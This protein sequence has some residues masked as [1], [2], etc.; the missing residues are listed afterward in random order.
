MGGAIP[1]PPAGFKL[2][3]PPPPDG[4][5]IDSPGDPGVPNIP[6][7]ASQVADSATKTIGKIIPRIGTQVGG[8]EAGALLGAPLGPL[9]SV[10]GAA[11]GGG[12]GNVVGSKLPEAIGGDPSESTLHAFGWGAIPEGAGR[13]IAG[14][15]ESR[16]AKR[17]A[18]EAYDA[19][20]DALDKGANP[21]PA[22]QAGRTAEALGRTTL[23]S[24]KPLTGEALSDATNSLRDDIRGPITAMRRQLGEPI[25]DAYKALKEDPTPLDPKQIADIQE[26]SQNVREDMIS[27]YPKAKAILQR[28]KNLSPPEAP[29]WM[30]PAYKGDHPPRP[31]TPE[32]FAAVQ[33]YL[34]GVK[35]YKPPTW[36]DIR[37]LRQANNQ[38]LR[39]AQGGD[40]HASAG[41]QQALDEQLMTK[42]PAGISRDRELY[43]SFMNRFPWRDATRLDRMGTPGEL[44]DYAFGGTPERAAEIAQGASPQGK[45]ALKEAFTDRVLRNANPD[46][47]LADQVKSVR[48]A[49]APHI[50]SGL[51]ASLYGAKNA[52]EL[53]N[54]FYLPEHF[55]QWKAA[56]TMS[57]FHDA[58]IQEM[59]DAIKHPKTADALEKGWSRVVQSLPPKTRAMLEQPTLP[60]AQMPVVMGTEEALTEGA[61]PG[62]SSIGGRVARRAELTIPMA[63]G[64]VAST[65]NP[66]FAAGQVATMAG[67]MGTSAGYR[68]LMENGGASMVGKL[69]G[70]QGGKASVRALLETLGAIG[71]QAERKVTSDQ[72]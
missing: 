2:D 20:I 37:E 45:Q 17:G 62:A 34:D 66:L 50:K 32:D 49:M 36:D 21:M 16:V 57:D 54:I 63:A 64:R 41:L 47:P 71:T 26:A 55:Q 59:T 44:A 33:K 25:G 5:K 11:I 61:K 58:A 9:G 53:R 27:P 8:A 40:I 30:Q 56:V 68:A 6:P 13:G 42:L 43:R 18:N 14:A 48:E 1:P 12:I 7:S 29:D 60:G 39:N 3:V 4:Y 15:V 19:I 46:A 69:Y 51:A 31:V 65:G 67:I 52:D 35:N 10:A 72:N 28:I 38:I 70:S 24:A 22:E 23:E